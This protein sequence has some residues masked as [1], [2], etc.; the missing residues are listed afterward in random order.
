MSKADYKKYFNISPSAKTIVDYKHI[1]ASQIERD[2][3]IGLLKKAK[4]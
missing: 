3:A 4:M 2:T 1:E